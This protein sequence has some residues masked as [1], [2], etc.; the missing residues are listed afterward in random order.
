M[1]IFASLLALVCLTSFFLSSGGTPNDGTWPSTCRRIKDVP[2]SFAEFEEIV[3]AGEPVLF[4]NGA[5]VFGPTVESFSNI[6][7]FIERL[8]DEKL[9]M[10]RFDHF[11]RPGQGMTTSRGDGVE[12][13]GQVPVENGTRLWRPEQK[14]LTMNEVMAA[15]EKS[16]KSIFFVEQHSIYE[17]EAKDDEKKFASDLAKLPDFVNEE[18]NRISSLNIWAGLNLNS[19]SRPKESWLHYDSW[20]NLMLQLTGRKQWTLYK[21]DQAEHLYLRGMHLITPPASDDLKSVGRVQK[22]EPYWHFS[23]VDCLN[24]D[25]ERFPNFKKAKATR[26]ETQP[27][28][29]LFLPQQT[30]HH[31]VSYPDE[32]SNSNMGLNLWFDSDSEEHGQRQWEFRREVN[33]RLFKLAQFSPGGKA[34]E[35][36][37]DGDEEKDEDEKEGK[38]E[39]SKEL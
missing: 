35:K 32:S 23:R 19:S 20:H 2:K 9:E 1:G 21:H 14:K 25:F 12:L 37:E 27:G 11:E 33:D 13:M 3:E 5:S 24:P 39:H 30:F 15:L 31:V 34:E 18:E 16:P 4:E 38:G 17:N 26:C 6:K 22:G 36:H 10:M 7:N 8:G 28:N 29:L